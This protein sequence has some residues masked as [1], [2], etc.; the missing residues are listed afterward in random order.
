MLQPA[1]GQEF[2]FCATLNFKVHSL[3]ID[4]WILVEDDHIKTAMLG[5]MMNM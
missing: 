1:R 2:D 4:W 3:F 5:I